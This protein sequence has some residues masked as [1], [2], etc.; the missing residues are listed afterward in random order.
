MFQARDFLIGGLASFALSI[1]L[2]LVVR[3]IARR[4]GIVDDPN[5]AP[6]RK[7]HGVP[8]PLLGGLAIYGAFAA[9]V[10]GYMAFSTLLVGDALPAKY[11]I[12]LLVGGAILMV[13]GI[14]DDVSHVPARRQILFPVF[15]AL[16]II[17]CGIGPRV[18]TNPLGGFLPLEGFSFRLLTIGDTPYFLTLPA[19][20]FTFLWLLGMMYTTKLLDG[21]DGLVSGM[22]VIGSLILFF[23]SIRPDVVQPGTAMLAVLFAGACAGFLL[24]NWHPATIFLG[25]GGSLLTGFV[26]GTLSIIAGGKIATALL[27]F[28][29]PIL[30][31]LWVMGRRFLLEH[32]SPF[33]G[34]DRGH[35]HFRIVDRGWSQRTAVLMYVALSAIFGGATLF[36]EGRGKALVLIL[37]AVCMVVIAIVLTRRSGENA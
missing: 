24:F 12:G 1:L 15:A 20:V 21:L 19:D 28:G 6:G 11:L 3:R 32:R 9:V 7:D 27:I 17:A 13:G 22:S 37:V 2:T 34:A 5:R 26:L 25:E 29:I 30:D 23:V 16:A 8:V 4:G 36:F 31:V 33:T 10:L 35:L 18:L 14:L